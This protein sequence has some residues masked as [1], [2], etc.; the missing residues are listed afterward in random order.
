MRVI[1]WSRNAGTQPKTRTTRT[2]FRMTEARIA[3]W[4]HRKRE[5]IE[6]GQNYQVYGP[7]MF[8]HRT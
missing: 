8:A 1:D 6:S 5:K 3:K 2:G 4:G 7:K